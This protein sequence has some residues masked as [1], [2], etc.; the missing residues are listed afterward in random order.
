MCEAALHHRV[1][2][3]ANGTFDMNEHP[4]NTLGP[5]NIPLTKLSPHTLGRNVQSKAHGDKDIFDVEVLIRRARR[6]GSKA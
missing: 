6:L 5:H 3:S 2:H 4:G 1:L